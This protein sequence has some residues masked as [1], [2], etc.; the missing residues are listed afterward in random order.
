MKPDVGTPPNPCLT[1]TGALTRPPAPK[2]LTTG[3]RDALRS[4][5]RRGEPDPI[6]QRR[7]SIQGYAM[8]A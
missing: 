6:F 1:L 3:L 4:A 8:T 2:N 5:S 7:E